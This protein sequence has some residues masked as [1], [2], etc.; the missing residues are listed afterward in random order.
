MQVLK[1][2][3]QESIL[4][5]AKKL[6]LYFGYE[7][8]SI[9]KIAKEAGISKSNLY[10]Y[11]K[12]KDEI[13]YKL[14]DSAAF[15]FQ[16]V[17]NFFDENRFTPKFGDSGF[18]EMFSQYI[19]QLIKN[20]KEGLILIMR[21]SDGT[22]YAHLKERLI[23][24]IAEKFLR[25]F[26]N[27]FD[28]AEI[29]IQVITENLFDGITTIAIQSKTDQELEKLLFGYIKYHSCGFLGLISH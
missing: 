17:I 15:Q 19:F 9:E 16:K 13:F 11:F 23:K 7:K 4:N 24:Q 5:S 20:H 10:N 27:E 14:T 22:K 25:D 26:P 8:T 6:F 21:S 3:I 1:D 18:S 12:S 2:D 28:N 29:L